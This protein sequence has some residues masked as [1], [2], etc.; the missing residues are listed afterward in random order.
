MYF[1]ASAQ[2]RKGNQFAI[3]QQSGLDNIGSVDM[4]HEKIVYV[5][6]AKTLK[7]HDVIWLLRKIE[8]P[9]LY[10]RVQCVNSCFENFKKLF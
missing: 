8:L 10:T 3:K 6:V 7:Q 9:K 4:V 1:R 2:E 5:L